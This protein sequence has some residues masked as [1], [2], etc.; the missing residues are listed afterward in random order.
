MLPLALRDPYNRASS[1]EQN[2]SQSIS[3]KDAEEVVYILKNIIFLLRKQLS[4]TNKYWNFDVFNLIIS[5][6]LNVSVMR[7]NIIY[8]FDSKFELLYR[9]ILIGES[10]RHVTRFKTVRT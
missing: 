2:R 5:I 8:Y 10:V 1:A 4:D 9:L 7:R 3:L 6:P